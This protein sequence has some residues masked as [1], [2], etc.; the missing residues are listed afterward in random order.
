M[1]TIHS[2]LFLSLL[3]TFFLVQSLSL[4]TKYKVR[5]FHPQK[6]LSML[7]LNMSIKLQ[8]FLTLAHWYGKPFGAY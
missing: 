4:S 6:I 2:K 5:E 1:K 8:I 3:L 7:V